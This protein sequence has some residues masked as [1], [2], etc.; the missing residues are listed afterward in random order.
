MVNLN[1]HCQCQ[2]QVAQS[3]CAIIVQYRDLG[4]ELESGYRYGTVLTSQAPW[5]GD[6]QLYAAIMASEQCRHKLEKCRRA[7]GSCGAARG[8]AS[9][10]GLARSLAGRWPASWPGPED[11]KFWVRVDRTNNGLRLRTVPRRGTGVTVVRLSHG[12]RRPVIPFE[13]VPVTGPG[14]EVP[15]CERPPAWALGSGPVV[16]DFVARYASQKNHGH[17][18]ARIAAIA[19]ESRAVPSLA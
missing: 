12:A 10:P 13:S 15:E 19:R 9:G 8:R 3:G 6:G 5:H 4:S 11:C 7:R 1:A 18:S 16:S 17:A 14:H 2:W